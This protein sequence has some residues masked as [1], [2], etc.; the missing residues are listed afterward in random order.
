MVGLRPVYSQFPFLPFPYVGAKQKRKRKK[1]KFSY[2]PPSEAMDG[3]AK[4]RSCFPKALCAL[5]LNRS[6]I[7]TLRPQG[8]GS[9]SPSWKT[10][11]RRAPLCI[12]PS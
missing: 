9:C 3:P 2:V 8:K 5:T 1:V 7:Y 11:S 12:S 6:V 4:Q 10:P